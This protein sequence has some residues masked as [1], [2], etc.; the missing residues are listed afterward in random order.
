[1]RQMI[2]KIEMKKD[3]DPS[4]LFEQ[5]SGIQNRYNTVTRKMMKMISL[6]WCWLQ[7]QQITSQS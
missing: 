1:M 6:Q 5:I 2:N 7:P 4:T 3:D